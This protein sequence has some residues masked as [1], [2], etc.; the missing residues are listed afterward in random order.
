MDQ[1]IDEFKSG[2]RTAVAPLPIQV[3]RDKSGS[4]SLN[5]SHVRRLILFEHCRNLRVVIGVKVVKLFFVDC[6]NIQIHLHTAPFGPLECFRCSGVYIK[7][8]TQLPFIY[9]E[10]V[11]D[12]LVRQVPDSLF[13]ILDVCDSVR[14][15]HDTDEYTVPINLFESR[16]VL[17]VT[18]DGFRKERLPRVGFD[19][20][21]FITD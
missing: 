12:C 2:Q 11:D 3:I 14:I 18:S 17:H 9:L 10:S 6:H 21:G 4:L 7:P 19:A 15:R 13:Y 20:M 5:D 16:S 8:H 1:V